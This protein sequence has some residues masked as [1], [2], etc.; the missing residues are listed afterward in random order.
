MRHLLALATLLAGALPAQA[1]PVQFT[2]VTQAAG[3]RFLHN[4]GAFGKKFLPE[5]MGAGCAFLDY[6]NDGWPDI[7]LVNGKDWP[8]RRPPQAGS[9]L[10]LYRNNG[11]GTFTDVTQKAGLAVELYGMGVAVGDYDNDGA[12]DIFITALGQSRLFRNSGKGTF[13]NVTK[14]AGLAGPNEFSTSAAWVDFDRDGHLDLFVAN[15]VQWSI[16]ADLFCTLDGT[17]KSYC[18]PESYKGASARLWRNRGDGT[19][20]DATRKT[21]IHD[22]TSKGLGVAVL[23][24]NQDGWPDL[25]LA[26]DTQPNKLYLNQRDGTFKEAGTLAGIAFSEDGVARAGMGVDAADYDRSGYPSILISNFSN[27]MLA[28]YHNEGN[29]LFVDE[30]PRSEVGRGSLLT[31]GFACFFFDYDLDGWLDIFVANGHIEKEIERVQKRVKYAQPPHLFRNTGKG[32]FEEVTGTLGKAFSQPRVARGAAYA[33][34]DNDGDLDLL[35]TTNG[36]PAVLLRNDASA[37][38]STGGNRNRALRMRLVGTKSNRSGIGAVAKVTAGGET[39]WLMLRSGSSYLSQ[40]E[41]VFTFGIGQRTQADTIE[42]RWPGGT[43]DKLEK[44]AAG[45]TIT[46]QEGKGIVASRPNQKK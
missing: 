25:L 40:S 4:T 36:G 35:L 20:E 38:L 26:N 24:S 27:Q 44:V 6:D 7:L 5:T 46:V 14:K 9:T 39:Q 41:L 19:F 37:S 2:D 31:L 3:I 13:V 34:I 33:D 18:T 8:G 30:A 22:P 42:I 45:Q 32:G 10:K 17:S 28:L 11:N 15:Y 43:V 21:G 12:V 1:P 29:G 16:E 23:D